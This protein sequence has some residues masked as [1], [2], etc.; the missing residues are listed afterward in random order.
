MERD[1]FQ[2]ERDKACARR[3]ADADG[4]ATYVAALENRAAAAEKGRDERL[5]RIDRLEGE[6]AEARVAAD[7]A[8]RR[9]DEFM[10]VKNRQMVLLQAARTGGPLSLD[11]VY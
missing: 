9:H 10:E 11:F 4:S 6:L 5:E 7:V 1:K 2:V 3:A 8:L